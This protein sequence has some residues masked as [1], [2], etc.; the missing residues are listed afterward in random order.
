MEREKGKNKE[1]HVEFFPVKIHHASQVCLGEREQER[2]GGAGA[3]KR[4]TKMSCG[5]FLSQGS[6][7]WQQMADPWRTGSQKAAAPRSWF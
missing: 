7:T 3:E 6:L 1:N 4:N 2:T 5:Q